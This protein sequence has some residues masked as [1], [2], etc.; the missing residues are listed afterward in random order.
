M[1]TYDTNDVSLLKYTGEGAI[2]ILESRHDNELQITSDLSSL[3]NDENNDEKRVVI[4]A[5][6]VSITD[7]NIPELYDT[8]PLFM[9]R[10]YTDIPSTDVWYWDYLL[11]ATNLGITNGD[12]NGAYNPD[13][14]LTRCQFVKMLLEA[15]QIDTDDA[16]AKWNTDHWAVDYMNKADE[17]EILYWDDTRG[18]DEIAQYFDEEIPRYE[19]AYILKT[20]LMDRTDAIQIPTLL[21][22]YAIDTQSEAASNWNILSIQFNDGNLKAKES[23]RQLYMNNIFVGDENGNLKLED[24]IS[25]AEATKIVIK[26]LF[27][28][29]ENLPQIIANVFE[30]EYAEPVN[31]YLDSNGIELNDIVFDKNNERKYVLT[32]D[33]EDSNKYFAEL[34]ENSNA[35]LSINSDNSNGC[36]LRMINNRKCYTLQG[37]G[38]YNVVITRQGVSVVGL[39]IS[40]INQINKLEFTPKTGGKYI[41][42]NNK[43]NIALDDLADANNEN[44]SQLLFY[45]EDLKTGTYTLMMEHQNKIT[46]RDIKIYLDIQFHSED[47]NASITIN[48]YGDDEFGAGHG[49][50]ENGKSWTCI[51][52]YASF[53]GSKV[54]RVRNN[55]P[56][57]DNSDP[58]ENWYENP[59]IVPNA[60]MEDKI[61]YPQHNFSGANTVWLSELY[62]YGEYPVLEK[63]EGFY[64]IMEFDIISDKGVDIAIAAFEKR[65]DLSFEDRFEQ[66]QPTTVAPYKYNKS[67]KG[68]AEFK[69]E[70]EAQLEFFVDDSTELATDKEIDDGSASDAQIIEL[71]NAFFPNGIQTRKWKTHMP[72]MA[73]EWGAS[74]NCESDILPLKYKDTL[75]G[76]NW[77]FDAYRSDT[78]DNNVLEAI[79]NSD[80][81]S[82]N[83]SIASSLGN[84]SVK[85][86]YSVTVTNLTDQDKIFAY[87]IQTRSN[88][89][90][91]IRNE[92]NTYKLFDVNG[93]KV[94]AICTGDAKKKG[95]IDDGTLIPISSDES[96]VKV[97]LPIFESTEERREPD[98]EGESQLMNPNN[99]TELQIVI[100][101][102]T[103]TTFYIDEVLAT[104]DAGSINTWM[105]FKDI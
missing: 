94:S 65:E 97:R 81:G 17:L 75:T 20:L 85:E 58:T 51:A 54:G 25:K 104:G 55:I 59:L 33:Q 13:A 50:D 69:P 48:K 22:N 6:K 39:K 79:L 72:A 68:T 96:D 77:T 9:L 26:P 37:G 2:S 5:A 89:F 31:L 38:T 35:E 102:N 45:Q 19:A 64:V 105:S 100:P 62:K 101:A 10:L 27:E 30:N 95:S 14:S 103:K 16:K 86:T 24:T 66:Y 18:D 87:T 52:G 83:A 1:T 32:I 41:F 78:G 91:S 47:M 46:E 36:T 53:W 92:D 60:A 61:Q 44:G 67:L 40:N 56:D 8:S 23:M 43:E 88:M 99:I 3:C 29:D 84:Y 93:E 49:N 11:E 57:I 82:T 12:E 34:S 42:S 70:T 76:R 80:G 7:G 28:I 74:I 21:Y 71:S 73:E 98:Q 15:A 90:L 4:T 63:D